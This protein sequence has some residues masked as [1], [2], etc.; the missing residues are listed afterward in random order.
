MYPSVA[1][2]SSFCAAAGLREELWPSSSA[3][4]GLA[5][6]ATCGTYSSFVWMTYAMEQLQA[7]S[8]LIDSSLEGDV[9]HTTGFAMRRIS[10]GIIRAEC[11]G[12]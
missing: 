7:P 3:L 6:A 2:A 11:R 12:V 10:A 9:G 5:T 4:L 1:D 8:R